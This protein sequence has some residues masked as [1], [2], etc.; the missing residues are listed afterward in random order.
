MVLQSAASQNRSLAGGKRSIILSAQSRG[1]MLD[2]FDASIGFAVS[3]SP[4]SASFRPFL[5]ETR[6]GLYLANNLLNSK[7]KYFVRKK[8]TA[9]AVGFLL[10]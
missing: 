7:L 9:N 3:A 6:K 2:K 4:M 8:P 1:K 10:C 5:A